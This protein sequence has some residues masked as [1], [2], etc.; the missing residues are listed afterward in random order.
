M[1]VFLDALKWTSCEELISMALLQLWQHLLHLWTPWWSRIGRLF[2]WIAHCDFEEGWHVDQ[3]GR[4]IFVPQRQFIYH[5]NV[6]FL[7]KKNLNIRTFQKVGS[8]V[9]QVLFESFITCKRAVWFSCNANAWCQE[10]IHTHISILLKSHLNTFQ[11][12]LKKLLYIFPI[13]NKCTLLPLWNLDICA[14]LHSMWAEQLVLRWYIGSLCFIV[15]PSSR[16][17]VTNTVPQLASK[18]W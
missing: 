14:I 3:N 15:L 10:M 2:W 5:R 17:V 18:V 6:I 4:I 8:S 7:K 12:K 13:H 9:L 16:Y 11:A 1:L